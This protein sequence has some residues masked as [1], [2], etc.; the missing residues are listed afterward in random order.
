M[1]EIARSII[2]E[3]QRK[4]FFMYQP[5]MVKVLLNVGIVIYQR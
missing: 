3:G 4:S 5:T 1:F 2:R